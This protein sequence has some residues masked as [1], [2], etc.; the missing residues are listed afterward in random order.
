MSRVLGHW[1][2]KVSSAWCGG[3]RSIAAAV[4]WQLNMR[5][6]RLAWGLGL[7][8]ASLRMGWHVDRPAVFFSLNFAL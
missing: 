8:Q 4:A 6:L 7:L 1:L 3:G 2:S 5:Q